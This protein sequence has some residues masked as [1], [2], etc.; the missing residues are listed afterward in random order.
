MK[1]LN[2]SKWM[3]NSVSVVLLGISSLVHATDVSTT[4]EIR[5]T[6]IEPTN[7]RAVYNVTGNL[8]AGN[9]NEGTTF[10]TLSI[11]GYKVST[12]FGDLKLNDNKGGTNLV[13]TD[14]SNP[15][16][17]LEYTVVYSGGEGNIR[18]VINNTPSSNPSELLPVN[19]LLMDVRL[20][21]TQ[22]NVPA[23]QYSGM[24]NISISNQ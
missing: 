14:S 8:T 2:T 6:V 20:A 1:L 11:D 9:M 15:G 7:I 21:S 13:L 24:L 10:G 17:T 3:L 18:P 22:N 12:T 5:T 19:N 4:A 16:N 23:G